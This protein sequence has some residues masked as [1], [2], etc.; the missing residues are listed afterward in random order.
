M[1]TITA[2]VYCSQIDKF[3]NNL[4]LKRKTTC[5][6]TYSKQ[7]SKCEIVLPH[8]QYCSDIFLY[9]YYLFLYCPTVYF[10]EE[11]KNVKKF[12]CYYLV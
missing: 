2:A 12:N 5:R 3:M 7:V 10:R 6:I 1:L 8:P 9:D 11:M 4:F